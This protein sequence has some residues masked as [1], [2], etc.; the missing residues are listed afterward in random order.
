MFI[1]RNL[2]F[3]SEKNTV[4]SSPW[5][6]SILTQQWLHAC[7]H[8]QMIIEEPAISDICCCSWWVKINYLDVT[9]VNFRLRGHT[10]AYTSTGFGWPRRWTVTQTAAVMGN[11]VFAFTGSASWGPGCPPAGEP[12]KTRAPCLSPPYKL[13]TFIFQPRREGVDGPPLPLPD[14]TDTQLYPPLAGPYVWAAHK[15]VSRILWLLIINLICIL[16]RMVE[17]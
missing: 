5:L 3:I 6:K 17:N 8:F 2:T 9:E 12:R 16:I 1:S 11:V 14:A 7:L 13:P 15:V 10:S 4:F